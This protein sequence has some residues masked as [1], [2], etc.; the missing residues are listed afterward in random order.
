MREPRDIVMKPL[1]TEKCN[2]LLKD[3]KYTFMVDIRANRVEIKNAVQAIFKVKVRDVN[4]MRVPGKPKRHGRFEGK[5][6]EWKKAIVTLEE[7]YS[8]PLFEGV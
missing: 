4:T 8:I 7:G 6:P 3:N 1:V 5:T 2:D